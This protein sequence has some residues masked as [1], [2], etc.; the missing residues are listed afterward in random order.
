MLN[1]DNIL[2]KQRERIEL[3]RRNL[4]DGSFNSYNEDEPKS[5]FIFQSIICMFI[6]ASLIIIK[7]TNSQITNTLT[8]SIDSQLTVDKTQE[9][10][11]FTQN[12]SNNDIYKLQADTI[13]PSDDSNITKTV[14]SSSTS[15]EEIIEQDVPTTEFIIDENML[16][17]INSDEDLLEKK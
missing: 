15:D 1:D 8:T 9:I 6:F 14:D 2:K 11:N 7:L 17:E 12:L 10:I 4:E 5:P 16:S 3:H 13:S